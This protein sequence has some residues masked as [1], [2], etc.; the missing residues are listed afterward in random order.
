MSQE[1]A[2]TI[3]L[4]PDRTIEGRRNVAKWDVEARAAVDEPAPCEPRAAAQ[5][6]FM[7]KAMLCFAGL[8]TILW[9][10]LLAWGAVRLIGSAIG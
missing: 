2:D 5:L 6:D 9:L 3:D 8:L 4:E 10:A 1:R 7:R